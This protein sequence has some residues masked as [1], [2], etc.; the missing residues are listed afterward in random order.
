[1]ILRESTF[2]VFL[3][4]VPA[5]SQTGAITVFS[6]RSV[7]QVAFAALELARAAGG[8]QTLS[9]LPFDQ[10]AKASCKV[11]VVLASGSGQSAMLANQLKTSPLSSGKPQSYGIRRVSQDGRGVIAVLATDV[12][13]AM[14]G[15]LDVASRS[16]WE[17]CDNFQYSLCSFLK[18]VSETDTFRGETE[19]DVVMIKLRIGCILAPGG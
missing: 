13:G 15:G 5:F 14:Y 4:A 9:N 19:T 3:L 10:F 18:C 8:T 16:V 17:L 1:M 7:P 12:N 11:C 6:D 2:S